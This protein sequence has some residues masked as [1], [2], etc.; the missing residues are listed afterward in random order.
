MEENSGNSSFEKNTGEDKKTV[1]GFIAGVAVTLAAIA[2]FL[3]CY[4]KLPFNYDASSPQSLASYKKIDEVLD[5]IDRYYMGDT[6]EQHLTDYMFLGL[7]SGLEDPYST[8]FTE[9]QYEEVQTVQAGQQQGIGVSIAVRTDDGEIEVVEVNE[10]GPAQEAGI[11]EGD[12]IKSVDGTDVS[13]MTTS[14]VSLLIQESGS[15]DVVI[16]IYREDTGE[17]LEISVTKGLVESVIVWGGMIEG[18]IGYIAIDSFTR[19]TCEQFTEILEQIEEMDASG[20]I[21]DLRGNGGGLV[22]AACD[23]LRELIPEGVLVYTEDK[24]GNREE[25]TSESGNSTTLPIAVL[26]NENTASAAEIFAGALQDHGAAEIV[27]T[28]TYGKGIIQD[29]FR[30]HDGSVVR[31]TVSHYYT[32]NGNNIHEVG[33]TPDM[34]VEYDENAETD[35]QLEAAIDLFS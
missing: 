24:Y 10:G 17:E 18:N 6:D 23:T 8:Y 14:E 12:V 27:G 26:V 4:I 22:S 1:K 7:V 3:A 32:P 28:Q 34:V 30:L 21:I 2:V 11:L 25:V 20:L 35:A 29:V 9:A 16:G 5:V 19:V 15:D 31:L 13:G 33:I